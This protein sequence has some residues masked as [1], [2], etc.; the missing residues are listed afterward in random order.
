MRIEKHCRA[1]YFMKCLLLWWT[2]CGLLM[3]GWAIFCNEACVYLQNKREKHWCKLVKGATTPLAA[4]FFWCSL[5]K[6]NHIFYSNFLKWIHFNCPCTGIS[7]ILSV[8]TTSQLYIATQ[9]VWMFLLS[10]Q[11]VIGILTFHFMEGGGI[12]SSLI[13]LFHWRLCMCVVFF[14]FFFKHWVSLLPSQGDALHKYWCLTAC[15]T[16]PSLRSTPRVW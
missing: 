4:F 3:F 1:N 15:I 6:K 8:I 14:L 16:T 10:L 9:T 2:S 13:A 7:F 11:R 5:L 12:S